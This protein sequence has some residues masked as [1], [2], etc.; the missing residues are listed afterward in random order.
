LTCEENSG[1][2]HKDEEE[3][4]EK[5]IYYTKIMKYY[6]KYSTIYA[7]PIHIRGLLQVYTKEVSMGSGAT[8]SSNRGSDKGP[9]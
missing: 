7:I 2:D 5:K 8:A 1:K 3:R 6:N 4:K 9:V